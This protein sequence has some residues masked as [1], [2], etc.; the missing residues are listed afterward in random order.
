MLTNVSDSL[1]SLSA[2]ADQT[3]MSGMKFGST[4]VLHRSIPK[5]ADPFA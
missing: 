4:F 2:S 1:R 5:K 3:S